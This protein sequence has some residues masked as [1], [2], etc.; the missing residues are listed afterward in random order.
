MPRI[1]LTRDF[2]IPEN[3]RKVTHRHSSAVAY[4]YKTGAG[5]LAAMAF[6]GKAQKPAWRYRF[7]T[8]AERAQSITRFF[9]A[10]Q[11]HEQRRAARKAE[12]KARGRGLAVGDVLSAMW[13]YEQTNIDWYEVTGLIGTSMVEVRQLAA[14]REETNWQ[15]GK[16]VPLSG[17]Y[18]GEPMRRKASDGHVKI[19]DVRSASKVDPI[20]TIG[21][22]PVFAAQHFTAY[23]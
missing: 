15:Q 1:T 20:A 6:Y 18:I 4:V 19:D 22:K 23:H 3:A 10:T 17:H 7:R 12:R 14:D 13:G 8:D 11:A 2:Y 9:E 21:G 5:H 16:T